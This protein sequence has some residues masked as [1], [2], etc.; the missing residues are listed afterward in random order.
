M[1]GLPIL[2]G[3]LASVHLAPAFWAFCALI[4]VNIASRAF[5][6]QTSIWDAIEDAGQ[7]VEFHGKPRK[8]GAGAS[9]PKMPAPP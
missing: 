5:M 8:A 4:F 1:V 6:C 9:L 2:V 3:G 7:T